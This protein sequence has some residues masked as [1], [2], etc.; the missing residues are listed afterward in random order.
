V[1]RR[2][3]D[4]LIGDLVSFLFISIT[5]LVNHEFRLQAQ[6]LLFATLTAFAT[7]HRVIAAGASA[8]QLRLRH[9]RHCYGDPVYIPIIALS[10]LV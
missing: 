5:W 3:S 9:P 2:H 8:L 10:Q 1:L 6:S 7:C 4:H